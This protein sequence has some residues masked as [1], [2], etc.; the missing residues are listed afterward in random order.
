MIYYGGMEVKTKHKPFSLYKKR[1]GERSFWYVRFWNE[2]ER[3]YY[4]CRATG[5]VASGKKERRSEAEQAAMEIMKEVAPTV[6]GTCLL[7][8]LQA[9]WQPDSKYFK[10]AEISLGHK[11]SAYYIKQAKDIIKN[12]ITQYEPF[13]RLSLSTI[14]PAAVRD[15]VL[16]AADKGFSNYMI[17]KMLFVVRAPIKYEMEFDDSIS[18][19]VA[20]VKLPK[21][22]Y[23]E[24]GSLTKEEAV[25]LQNCKEIPSKDRAAMLL[26]LLCGMRLGEV[27]G[28]HWDDIDHDEGVIHITHNWQDLEGLKC[29]K[30]ESTGDVPLPAELKEAL[31][32]MPV[33]GKLVFSRA[34]DEK[35]RC[36]SHFRKVFARVMDAIGIDKEEREARN[37]S[38]HSLRHSFVS[39]GRL[40]G[41]NDFEMQGLSRHKSQRVM[42]RYSH[43]E[44]VVSLEKARETFDNFYRRGG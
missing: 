4:K 40:S 35:P 30:Y 16:W 6:A 24:K 29:P 33:E 17:K 25:K 8:V 5:V 28:L 3:R 18:D 1:V 13:S 37:L 27:R 38:F 43:P 32:G 21:I 26:G 10:E 14:T 31:A 9:Y 39:L 22:K 36:Y 41:L 11:I 12:H 7:D 44:Q 23:R 15:F 34:K 19:P 42:E 20:R 2:Q